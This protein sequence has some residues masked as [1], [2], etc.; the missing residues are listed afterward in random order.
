MLSMCS[1]ANY[2]ALSRRR[3]GGLYLR[4]SSLVSFG[5]CLPVVP[6]RVKLSPEEKTIGQPRNVLYHLMTGLTAI[7]TIHK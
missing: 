4:L 5:D 2:F 3:P 7:T 6:P 1:T